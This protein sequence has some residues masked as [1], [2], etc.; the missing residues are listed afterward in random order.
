MVLS[1]IQESKVNLFDISLTQ[2]E[3]NVGREN[4]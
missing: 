1:V 3:S 4:I 2:S